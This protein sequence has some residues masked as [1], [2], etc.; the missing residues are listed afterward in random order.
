MAQWSGGSTSSG[1][2]GGGTSTPATAAALGLVSVPVAG[3][4]L[5][6]G[7]GALSSLVGSD[8]PSNTSGLGAPAIVRGTIRG[9]TVNGLTVGVGMSAAVRT[10]NHTALQAALNYAV[11][12]GKFFELEPN[13][14]EIISPTGGVGLQVTPTAVNNDFVWRGTRQSRIIQYG[15]NVSVLTIGDPTGGTLARGFDMRG[16]RVEY[17]VAQGAVITGSISGTT[18]TVTAVASAP[19]SYAN[20]V[21]VGQTLSGSGVTAGTT[22]TAL[23]TGTGG[24]GTYTVSA[25]QTVASTTINAV[26]TNANTLQ[27]G[28]MVNCNV[29][30]VNVGGPYSGTD[31]YYPG[32]CGVLFNDGQGTGNPYYTGSDQF[33][34]CTFEDY[35]VDGAT[36]CLVYVGS[37]GTG[38]IFRNWYCHNGFLNDPQPLYT[39][40]LCAG[41]VDGIFQQI[42]I[43][44]VSANQI[45]TLGTMR[46]SHWDD[47][48]IESALL[49]GNNPTFLSTGSNR[50]TFESLNF[51]GTISPSATGTASLISTYQEDVDVFRNVQIGLSASPSIPFYIFNP[52]GLGDTNPLLVAENIIADDF[53]A[54]GWRANCGIDP[55]LPIANFAMPQAVARYRF[56]VAGSYIEGAQIPSITANYTHYACSEDAL[57][58]VPAS[59]AASITI[60][61]ANKRRL[62]GLGSSL[63]PRLG[64][65]VTIRRLTGAA[66][67]SL[68]IVDQAGST[69]LVTNTAAGTSMLF[70]WNGTNYVVVT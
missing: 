47:I 33:F 4:L 56:G 64:A 17:G 11:S 15:S 7:S 1:G 2:T 62:S 67:N 41:A 66:A 29:S 35:R 43:E 18:L 55:N 28:S 14:Y 34:S 46:G 40:W 65:T 3:S 6:S 42:N 58:Y 50:C 68:L 36:Y 60:T 24:T 23:G 38:S 21:A 27:M 53:N 49:T 19:A 13:V 16:L 48:H 44:A 26:A 61:L 70:T 9:A 39:G 31:A 69:T 5:V 30:S 37:E 63:T 45:M 20:N 54:S 8:D 52:G 10:A 12:N 25:S 51:G 59:L 32:Y 57:I 22:I